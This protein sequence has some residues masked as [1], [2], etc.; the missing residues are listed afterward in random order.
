MRYIQFT[1]PIVRSVVPTAEFGG[2]LAASGF[3]RQLD[4]L[5]G[6]ALN[7][8]AEPIRGGAFPV[9]IYEDK[10][11]AYVRAE[12]PGVSREAIGVELEDGA[13][14]IKASRKQKTGEG[15][16][17]VSF[18]RVITVPGDVQADKVA[19]AYENGI[20]TVTLPKS[21]VAK[22]RKINVSAN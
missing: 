22:P 7:G 20:L 14:S 16:D 1:Q 9:D 18:S 4:W 5:F 13:L 8:F 6:T 11:N 17:E 21:E 19:A 12:L 10:D 2:R 15:E 3:D